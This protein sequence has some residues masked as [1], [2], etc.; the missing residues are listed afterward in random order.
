MTAARV[1]FVA[2]L[3]LSA[4][5]ARAEPVTLLPRLSLATRLPIPGEPARHYSKV[6]VEAV[7]W[8]AGDRRGKALVKATFSAV[9]PGPGADA[10]A[11]G[12]FHVVD[13]AGLVHLLA[14]AL[15]AQ[16]VAA[17]AAEATVFY[18]AD[19]PGAPAVLR[20]LVGPP[21]KPDGG[22]RIDLAKRA[23]TPYQP[24]KGIAEISWPVLEQMAARL[25]PAAPPEAPPTI[26]PRVKVQ[27]AA[28]AAALR[29]D[30]LRDVDL[31][32]PAARVTGAGPHARRLAVVRVFV[33][34]GAKAGCEVPNDLFYADDV[35]G[36][37]PAAQAYLAAVPA[38]G[39]YLDVVEVELPDAAE[40]GHLF[41]SEASGET[42]TEVVAQLR[43]DLLRREL[44]VVQDVD[45]TLTDQASSKPLGGVEVWLR[46]S[47][48]WRADRELVRQARTGA[49]G[50]FKFPR[51]EPGSYVVTT[52]AGGGETRQPFVQR[53]A[54]GASLKVVVASAKPAP[55][56]LGAALQA[57]V[58]ADKPPP[59]YVGVMLQ[60][61]RGGVIVAGVMGDS[62]AARAGLRR[63]DR[64][65]SVDG[66][67]VSD[68]EGAHARIPGK[69]GTSARIVVDRGGAKLS[70]DVQ[71]APGRRPPVP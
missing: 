37:G 64:I 34:R 18:Q 21:L 46:G 49:D 47:T 24:G 30:C 38:F 11:D 12:W 63:G 59:G 68:I 6:L 27:L 57:L 44:T 52:Q 15:G 23:A 43:L 7:E 13:E 40:R 16:E 55:A 48:D 71:R 14:P 39:T 62:G 19:L 36:L 41:L 51:I 2:L 35:G 9:L 61:R 5:P 32:L 67:A 28:A 65:I 45:G 4:V 60:E 53:A 22:L 1:T 10:P 20:L 54:A 56:D 29:R 33:N 31:L 3:C 17:G 66:H 50:R 25:L 26:A 58:E 42:R 8:R 70:L 69:P